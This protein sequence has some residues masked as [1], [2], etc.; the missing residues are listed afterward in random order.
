MIGLLPDYNT[1]QESLIKIIKDAIRPPQP[2]EPMQPPIRPPQPIEPM[3]PPIRPPQP[4]EPVQPPIRPPQ[5]VEPYQPKPQTDQSHPEYT[6][7]EIGNIY[8]Q[9]NHPDSTHHKQQIENCKKKLKILNH[10]IKI[11]KV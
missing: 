2:V 9:Y 7:Q 8:E 10:N 4:V 3:Q 11:M 6:D 1:N 5:P